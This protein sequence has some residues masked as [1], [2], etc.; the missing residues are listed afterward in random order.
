MVSLFFDFLGRCLVG[1]HVEL[2]GTVQ[3]P[4]A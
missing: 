2:F 1:C 4:T 3:L